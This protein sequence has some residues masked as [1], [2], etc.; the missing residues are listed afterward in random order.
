MNLKKRAQ[1]SERTRK[2]GEVTVNA[3]LVEVNVSVSVHTFIIKQIP[4]VK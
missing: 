4:R 3:R 2:K 1:S